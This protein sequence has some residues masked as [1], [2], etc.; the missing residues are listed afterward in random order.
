MKRKLALTLLAANILSYLIAISLLCLGG[1]LFS[2]GATSLVATG[3]FSFFLGIFML[4]LSIY[5]SIFLKKHSKKR[6]Q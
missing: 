3:I 4:L 6:E 1:F 2:A 5:C